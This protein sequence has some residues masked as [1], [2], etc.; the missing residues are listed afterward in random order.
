MFFYVRKGHTRF[1]RVA[2]GFISHIGADL[3]NQFI[4]P[5]VRLSCGLSHSANMRSRR[6]KLVLHI[7]KTEKIITVHSLDNCNYSTSFLFL[8]NP[9]NEIVITMVAMRAQ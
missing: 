1:E 6:Q 9:L 2:Y 4:K 7:P 3:L 5:A 8:L